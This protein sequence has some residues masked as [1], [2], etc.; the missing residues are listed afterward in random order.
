MLKVIRSFNVVQEL[1]TYMLHCQSILNEIMND[2]VNIIIQSFIYRGV[3][4]FTE[5]IEGT[6]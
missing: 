4:Y 2:N 1:D 6:V 3:Y 5:P